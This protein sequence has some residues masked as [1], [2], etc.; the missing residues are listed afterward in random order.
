MSLLL[1]DWCQLNAM[2]GLSLSLMYVTLLE[3]QFILFARVGIFEIF[4]PREYLICF[5]STILSNSAWTLICDLCLLYVTVETNS[6]IVAELRFVYLFSTIASILFLRG[7][8]FVSLWTNQTLSCK[9]RRCIWV[10][11]LW[12]L[13][14]RDHVRLGGHVGMRG[15]IYLLKWHWVCLRTMHATTL[16]YRHQSWNLMR[17]T[18]ESRVVCMMLWKVK[19]LSFRFWTGKFITGAALNHLWSR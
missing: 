18:M 5:L 6:I 15:L 4:L 9:L 17:H 7:W 19:T 12:V 3:F 10:H 1:Q 14:E 8:V 13:I 2:L 11:V 16:K